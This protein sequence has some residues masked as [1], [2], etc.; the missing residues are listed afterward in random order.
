MANRYN[1][2]HENSSKIRQK[3]SKALFQLLFGRTFIA[4]ILLALQL[5]LVSIVF[6]KFGE[7]NEVFLGVFTVFA[8][9]ITIYIINSEE[10][11]AF[12]LAW[13][14]LVCL[15]PVFGATLFLFVQMNP[16]NRGLQ[17]KLRA[18]LEKGKPYTN[19]SKRDS[20]Y[21]QERCS[22]MNGIV[23]YIQTVNQLPVYQ[24]QGVHFYRIGEEKFEDLLI[25][26]KNAK[27]YIFLEY[28]IIKKGKMWNAI[29]D[30]LVEKVKEGVEVRVLYDGM[31]SLV[32]LPYHYPKKLRK[33]GIQAKM[34]SP[35]KPLFSTHQN[36]RD[37]RKIAIIDGK[38]AYNGGINLADEYI[39]LDSMYGHWKDTAVRIKGQ[40]VR[41]FLLMFLQMWNLENKDTNDYENYLLNEMEDDALCERD[42]QDGLVIPYNDAPTNREDIAATIYMD[43]LYNARTYVYI[44]TPY[45]VLD[46][47]MM[48]ALTTAVKKGVDV[49]I[50]MPKIP[51]KKMVFYLSRTFY[52]QLLEAGV[53]IYEYT[54]GFMHAKE[55]IADDEKAIVGSINLDFRSLYEHFEC[56]T[57]LY[58]VE[59]IKDIKEDFMDAMDRSEE[60]TMKEYQSFSLATRM[61]GRVLRIIA[62]L[63]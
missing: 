56:A 43:M 32:Y 7:E 59:Q 17:K 2:F 40:C 50:I 29:L 34:F 51:D 3:S 49:R 8:A 26:L 58:K 27:K 45:L 63:V 4:M 9:A 44:M 5:V 60:I 46:N 13:M 36:N 62:P 19:T 24:N 30:I 11:P 25:D 23:N 31:C 39:N 52:P 10:N 53:K 48:V 16:G 35:I 28:F 41:S 14:P 33:L 55:F 37:H 47:E 12:K 18:Q 42:Y 54:P 20:T 21:V 6:V 15:F 38:I 61:V 57:L 22:E 1:E